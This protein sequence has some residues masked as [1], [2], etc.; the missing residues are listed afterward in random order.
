MDGSNDSCWVEILNWMKLLALCFVAD[1]AVFC[2]LVLSC[3]IH[4]SSLRAAGASVNYLAL[5]P[6]YESRQC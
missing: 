4:A 3:Y 6:T 2:L 1:A 5:L